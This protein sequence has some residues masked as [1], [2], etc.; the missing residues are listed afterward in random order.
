M[1]S[2]HFNDSFQHRSTT[3][4]DTK[5]PGME[6]ISHSKFI[7]TKESETQKLMRFLRKAASRISW[8]GQMPWI[9]LIAF[10]IFSVDCVFFPRHHDLGQGSYVTIIVKVMWMRYCPDAGTT[11]QL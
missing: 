5:Y 6:E 9:T 8:N 3:V 2:S 7:P 1:S 11:G 4:R 10:G